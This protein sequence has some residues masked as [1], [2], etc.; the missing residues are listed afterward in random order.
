M[1][2]GNLSIIVNVNNVVMVKLSFSF[3]TDKTEQKRGKNVRN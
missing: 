1:I 2:S 3:Q